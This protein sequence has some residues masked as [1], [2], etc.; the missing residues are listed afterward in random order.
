MIRSG[1]TSAHATP[2]PRMI[3]ARSPR[4]AY[5]AGEIFAIHCIHSGMTLTG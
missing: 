3:E 2:V 4:S 5:V 1:H